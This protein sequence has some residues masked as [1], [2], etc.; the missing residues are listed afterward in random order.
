MGV[1]AVSVSICMHNGAAYI[2]DTLN[3][4][5][6][7]TCQDFEIVLVDDGSTD[8][9]VELVRSTFADP[10]LK[11]VP[12]RQQT[13]RVARPVSL[14][15]ARGEFVAFIDH[16]D[17]WLPDK[18]ERQ[19]A[20]ARLHPGAAVIFS[21]CYFIDQAGHIFGESA[22]RYDLAGVDLGPGRGHLE[23]LR[24]G[25]FIS[26]STALARMSTVTATGGFNRRYQYVSDYDLWLRL[27]RTHALHYIQEP[28]A[29]YRI[30]NTQFTQ[31][32]LDITLPEHEALLRPVQKSASYSRAIRVAVGDALYGQHKVA[33]RT[34]LRQRRFLLAL[35]TALAILRYLDR[36][37]DS[38]RHRISR[39]SIGP[40]FEAALAS[41]LH[42]ATLLRRIGHLARDAFARAAAFL[43]NLLLRARRGP[44]AVWRRLRGARRAAH[45]ASKPAPAVSAPVTAKGTCIWID[46]SALGRAQTGYFSLTCELI[47][48]LALR[49]EHEVH[50][51]TQRAGREALRGRLGR[52]ADRV[53]FHRLGWY[54]LHW[55]D[56]HA[57]AAG[58]SG[59]M[60]L[61]II[62]GAALVGAPLT[63]GST[64]LVIAA[65]FLT[66]LATIA[67][68]TFATDLAAR[69]GVR[70]DS[71]V[72]R[73][74]RRASAWFRAPRRR[75]HRADI[76]EVL[77]WRGRFRWSDSH[78]VAI[79]QDLTTR[80]HPELHT[81]FNVA[82]FDEYLG[83]VQRHAHVIA[84]VSESSRRD[85]TAHLDVAPDSI[86]VIPMPLDPQYRTP[87]LSDGYAALHGISRP[88][89]LC[90]GT[91]EP[92]KNLR[93]LVRA[94]ELLQHEEL[95][96]DHEL[97]L[98][99][100]EGWDP[101]FAEFLWG[102][103][104]APRVRVL[105]FVPGDHLP[106][107]YHFAAVVI[108]PSL[109]EGFGLPV[110]EAMA[111]S[112]VVLTS[113]GSSLDE[114]IGPGGMQFD[115]Y[116]SEDIARAMLAAL[117]LPAEAANQYRRQCRARAE[118]F[119]RRSDGEDV[120]PE[121]RSRATAHA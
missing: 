60:L 72:A 62:A 86:H 96:R 67:A 10:R 37:G 104:M 45:P 91:R 22:D 90:V 59:G 68:D 103:D 29:A 93:R 42:M 107:L 77:M 106:S 117:A 108:Y 97:V 113:R 95:A 115:P 75:R 121:L 56:V 5:F 53:L 61:A 84:T 105:G 79:V 63:N 74:L 101:Q 109:Y 18:L 114:V 33:T 76:V 21:N 78:R 26:Y 28:L 54:S 40:V 47:R 32:R 15:H 85:I 20:A 2:V 14:A 102:S 24:R 43:H 35:Q 73:L 17:L 39:T 16:D 89:V 36:V 100:P 57:L 50:V 120:L 34:F 52:D 92:R 66:A 81:A 87:V 41:R 7:Q 12:Q 55:S 38:M 8:G 3:S 69:L 51:V 111:S 119:F 4:V 83:Y 44:R 27:A 6:A 112:A 13:L 82:E 58:P 80:T 65:G 118:T 11:I 1:P 88:Y 46:G 64:L 71:A 98:V 116:S 99:G 25:C 49:P 23:L 30:H 70:R 48:T 31:A 94:F 19:L 110:L 9:G